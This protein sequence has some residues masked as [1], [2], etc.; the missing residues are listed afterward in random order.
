M[1][2]VT[3]VAA[4]ENL[5]QLIADVNDTSIPVTIVSNEGKNAVLISE[6][7]WNAIQ[8]TAFLNAVPGMVSSIL[9]SR[10]EPI[11]EC[12]VYDEDEPW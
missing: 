2:A 4:Q 11:A 3:A 10:E 6:A 8:E 12:S 1:T 7:D 5:C 9:A